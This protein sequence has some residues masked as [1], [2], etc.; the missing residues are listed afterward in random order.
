MQAG[1]KL[2]ENNKIERM[3]QFYSFNLLYRGHITY[4]TVICNM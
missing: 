4:Y 2:E 1:S 3:P